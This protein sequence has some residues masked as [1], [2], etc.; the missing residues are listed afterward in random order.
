[1]MVSVEVPTYSNSV[2]WPMGIGAGAGSTVDV[3]RMASR[4]ATRAF[5]QQLMV[6]LPSF[7]VRDRRL[8]GGRPLEQD[9]PARDGQPQQHPIAPAARER[10]G[11]RDGDP[12]AETVEAIE[13]L[14]RH[15]A[16]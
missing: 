10:R 12:E 9:R 6:N 11:E 13:Q 3:D 16:P 5:P 2:V 8:A 15:A 4:A 1:M 14:A 7:D